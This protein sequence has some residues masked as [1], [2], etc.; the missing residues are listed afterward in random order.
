MNWLQATARDQSRDGLIESQRH[1]AEQARKKL[2]V[3][4]DC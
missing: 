1:D 3:P 2:R 4:H